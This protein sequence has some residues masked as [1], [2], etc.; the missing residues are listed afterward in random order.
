VAIARLTEDGALLLSAESL[1]FK[2]WT[3]FQLFLTIFAQGCGVAGYGI[4]WAVISGINAYPA[5]YNYS[6][7]A[8]S[9]VTFGT[10]SALM[11]IGNFREAPFMSFADTNR[12]KG[13]QF[14]WECTCYSNR[15]HT[16][17]YSQHVHV[18]SY[19]P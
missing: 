13:H 11:N 19:L 7:V 3:S 2:S 6:G 14:R 8:S 5:W 15:S 12:S 1:C 10:I 17:L 4:D 9:G 18:V 16:S